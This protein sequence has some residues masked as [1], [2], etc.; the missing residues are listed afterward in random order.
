VCDVSV[1]NSSNASTSLNSVVKDVQ[2]IGNFAEYSSL[3]VC[4]LW[5][6]N[7]KNGKSIFR[8]A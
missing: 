7:L 1:T 5:Y 3:C 2:R 6:N 8:G 4:V